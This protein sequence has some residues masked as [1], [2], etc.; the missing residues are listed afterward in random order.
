MSNSEL[1]ER[2]EPCPFC[3]ARPHHGLGKVEHC[4]LH[5]DP[6]QR[7]QVWCPKGHATTVEVNRE[8]ATAAWN[9]RAARLTPTPEGAREALALFDRI[10]DGDSYRG[11]SEDVLKLREMLAAL[12]SIE[13]PQE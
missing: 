2:L 7:Y 4:Q 13:G 5:G 11:R 3:G 12:S 9:T 6:F 1:A 8:Q 10:E